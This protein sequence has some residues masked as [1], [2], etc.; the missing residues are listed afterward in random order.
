MSTNGKNL[1]AKS[2]GAPIVSSRGGK[3]AGAGR[4]TNAHRLRCQH[5]LETHDGPDIV[6][7]IMTDPDEAAL[8]RLAAYDRLERGAGYGAP[9]PVSIEAQGDVKV[10][11]VFDES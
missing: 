8:A 3:R 4:P 2:N 7:R 11:V 6:A 9:K 1:P 10:I 5:L